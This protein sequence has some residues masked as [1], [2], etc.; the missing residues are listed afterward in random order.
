ME[1]SKRIR[2]YRTEKK[3][4]QKQLGDKLNVS[5]KTI[6]SWENGR[7]YPDIQMIIQI[8][9]FFDLSLDEFLKEDK[10]IVKKISTDTSLRK[11][12]SIRIRSLWAIVIILLFVVGY[13]AYQNIDISTINKSEDISQLTLAE[14]SVRFDVDLPVYRSVRGYMIESPPTDEEGVARLSIITGL[15]WTFSNIES[16]TVLLDNFKGIH[17]IQV[18]DSEGNILKSVVISN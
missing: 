17:E 16:K 7:T 18:T 6:S 2:A 3:L 1:I 14:E 13:I 12:Q 11:K 4:T 15:D 10:N 9:E 5:D 8:A